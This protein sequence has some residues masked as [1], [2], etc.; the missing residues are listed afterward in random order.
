M[1]TYTASKTNARQF[2]ALTSIEVIEF[3]FLLTE[4]APRSDRFF[5][6]RTWAGKLRQQPR[7]QPQVDEKLADP[8]QQLFFLMVYLKNNPLQSFQAALFDLS[9]G[10]VSQMVR[11][12]VN[13][14]NDTLTALGLSPCQDTDSLRAQLDRLKPGALNMDATERAVARSTAQDA[15][16]EEYSGKAKDHT[17]KNQLLCDDAAY[18]HFLSLTY[19][20]KTHD[21]ALADAEALELPA[22]QLLRQDTGYQGYHPP[23]VVVSQ[24]L[25]KPRGKELT[26]QQKVANQA[27]SSQ[28][29]I[30]EHAINGIKRLHCLSG[31]L[32][33][34]GWGIRD[35]LMR[36]GTALHNLRVSSP[37][38]DYKPLAPMWALCSQI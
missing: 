28:R 17:C 12:L 38:R 26:D 14:L 1:L 18:V 32:R 25:K 10:S 29:V 8:A 13:L 19:E 11:L 35:A 23:G 5:R 33:L 15:Q 9:Q 24:P 36:V 30:V 2:L 22:G 6:Y 37:C 27:I 31:R 3:E 16:F 20:G 21:K 34:K 7:Y 4:F